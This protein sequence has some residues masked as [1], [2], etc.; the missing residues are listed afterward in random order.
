MEQKPLFYSSIT[1]IS[2]PLF[3][4]QKSIRS[5]A[6]LH[7]PVFINRSILLSN[8]VSFAITFNYVTILKFVSFYYRAEC[9]LEYFRRK[10]FKKI[11]H[12]IFPGHTNPRRKMPPADDSPDNFQIIPA[13]FL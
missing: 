10:K 7:K 13:V 4:R 9:R 3:N 8:A 2:I 12:N 5:P 11:T 1:I 6:V